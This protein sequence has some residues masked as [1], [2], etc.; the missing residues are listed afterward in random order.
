M[1]AQKDA[2][3]ADIRADLHVAA[4]ALPDLPAGA[5]RAVGVA[6]ALFA[7]LA[8]RIELTPADEVLRTRVRVPGVVKVRLAAQA[9]LR[10]PREH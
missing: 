4:L 10:T 5:R 2:A 3:L 6:Y 7:E 9:V 1:P 8:R